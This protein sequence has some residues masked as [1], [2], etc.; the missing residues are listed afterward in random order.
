MSDELKPPPVDTGWLKSESIRDPSALVAAVTIFCGFACVIT[1][2][3]M[4]MVIRS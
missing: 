4:V 3:V 1:I 2:L